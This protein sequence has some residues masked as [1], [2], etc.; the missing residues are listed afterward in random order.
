MQRVVRTLLFLF[1][2]NFKLNFGKCS[3][4][5]AIF[6]IPLKEQ[7]L[8]YRPLIE[9]L[10]HNG[11]NVMVLTTDPIDSTSPVANKI[12]QIDLSFVYNLKL[13]ENLNGDGSLDGSDMLKSVFDVLRQ[14]A[15]AEL[16]H[17]SVQSLIHN[18]TEYFDAVIVE[19]SGM[20]LMNAFAHKFQAPLIGITPAAAFL[21]SHEAVGNPNHPIGYPSIFMPFSENLNI[22]QKISSFMFT[23]WYR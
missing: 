12:E 23:V 5:L 17:E 13:L 2:L 4:I 18:E 7:Q 21:N 11:H 10:V 14:I 19:W 6:P 20:T 16:R 9:Q 1:T 8:V 15:E 22:L 3:R